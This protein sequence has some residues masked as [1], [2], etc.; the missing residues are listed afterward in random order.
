MA[1]KVQ[2]LRRQAFRDQQGRCFYC[3]QP[4]WE[5]DVATFVETYGIRKS[6]S[7]YL[8]CTA[9]HLQARCDRGPD[10]RGNI[11]AACLWCN[12]QRHR[13]LPGKAPMPGVHRATVRALVAQ[14]KWH[15]VAASLAALQ[16]RVGG[17]DARTMF[18]PED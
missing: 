6:L 9:E 5:R 17:R 12:V 8:Q 3:E 2:K 16:T 10:V 14:G 1:S 13:G 4:L 15:P 11:A 7:K 18:C